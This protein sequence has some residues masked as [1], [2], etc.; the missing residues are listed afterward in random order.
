[1][2]H[3]MVQIGLVVQLVVRVMWYLHIQVVVVALMVM[4]VM[5]M[6]T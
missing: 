4:V 1:M 2:F 3:V 5:R 6:T